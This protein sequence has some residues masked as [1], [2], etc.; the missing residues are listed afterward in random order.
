[1]S[2]VSIGVVLVFNSVKKAANL[3]TAGSPI[4]KNAAIATRVRKPYINAF[5]KFLFSSVLILLEYLYAI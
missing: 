5:L 3:A 2:A 4:K 1:M